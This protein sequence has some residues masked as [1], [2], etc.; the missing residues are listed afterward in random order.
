MFYIIKQIYYY[1]ITCDRDQLMMLQFR[2]HN[3]PDA[4]QQNKHTNENIINYIIVFSGI[5]ITFSSSSLY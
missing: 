2:V 5:Q 4:G 3:L 1:F